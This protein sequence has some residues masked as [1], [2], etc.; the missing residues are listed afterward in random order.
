MNSRDN[1]VAHVSPAVDVFSLG[2]VALEALQNDRLFKAKQDVEAWVARLTGRSPLATA[3][4]FWRM[5]RLPV[6]WQNFVKSCCHPAPRARPRVFDAMSG[7]P[8]HGCEWVQARMA[9]G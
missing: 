3:P 5:L 1:L 9:L 8:P 4:V 7:G 2:C 6:P